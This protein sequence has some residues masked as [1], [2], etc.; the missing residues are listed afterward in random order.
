M[1]SMSEQERR[2][3]ARELRV[4]MRQQNLTQI[5]L[6]ARCEVDQSLVSRLL[7]RQMLRQSAG[8]QRVV[9]Y[10]HHR[11]RDAM[12]LA[13][14]GELKAFFAAGGETSVLRDALRVL[15]RASRRAS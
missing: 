9:A 10:L 8:V 12:P 2:S 11:E 7:N 4:A 13:I 15:T 6:A 3:L 1:A 14:K 5:D